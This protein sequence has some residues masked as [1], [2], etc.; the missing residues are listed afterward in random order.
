[1]I[2]R[3]VFLCLCVLVGAVACSS[4]P[5]TIS[6]SD[7]ATVAA[8][9]ATG[10]VAVPAAAPPT[11]ARPFPA[12]VAM[13]VP[14]L[15][16]EGCPVIV[17]AEGG[18]RNIDFRRGQQSLL[19]GCYFDE[20][21]D[22][23]RGP[24]AVRELVFSHKPQSHVDD[25]VVVRWSPNAA[26]DWPSKGCYEVAATYTGQD[27]Y[28]YCLSGIPGGCQLGL[29]ANLQFH[30]FKM[31]DYTEIPSNKWGDYR[32]APPTATP[33]PTPKPTATPTPAPTLTP[34]PTPIPTPTLAPTPTPSPTPTPTPAPTPYPTPTATPA[35]TATP[36]PRA[37]PVSVEDLRVA[38]LEMINSERERV[39][40]P[41]VVMGVNG[42]AQVHA[43]ATLEG[44]F[45]SHWGLDGT[46]P[47]MR[48]ALAGGQQINGEIVSGH[49]Y[50]I[51]PHENFQRIEPVEDLRMDMDGFVGSPAHLKTILDPH[52]RK[53][54]LGIAWDAF[55][56]TI[57]QQFEGDYVEFQQ[58]PHL[59][60]DSLEFEGS[61]ENGAG[62]H[63]TDGAL[64]VAIYYHPLSPLTRGQVSHTYCLDIGL[65]VASLLPPPA[66]GYVYGDMEAVTVS[67]DRCVSPY[68]I[69]ST[70]P[71][72]L[73]VWESVAQFE[74]VKATASIPGATALMAWTVADQWDTDADS[75][76][77]SADIGEV[78]DLNGPG[79]YQVL[80]WG[81]VG[82][83]TALIAD[84][85]VFYGVQV[86]Q[87]YAR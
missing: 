26:R 76:R 61:T 69:P 85:P 28:V 32:N 15:N 9:V 31:L 17:L 63:A 78:L 40:A 82:G 51:Q 53:V 29:G 74:Q 2:P 60:G 47:G 45:S 7:P 33:E 1:M 49:D 39:G 58:V 22:G 11:Q 42:A 43:D 80:L 16:C 44:C 21:I 6:P 23:P 38:M 62:A 57:V 19:V 71:G 48:Y 65:L 12:P 70:T 81:S 8:A 24:R 54:N 3:D 77:V 66:P 30:T 86:P 20:Q 4:P 87:G 35:P 25:Q 56:M 50:C 14:D 75:F 46:T 67:Y 27:D 13:P 18:L 84:Y 52:Y 79:V 36:T 37:P 5:A 64:E 73:T 68:D 41:A 55:N 59:Q 34:P 72:S 10:V 83:Q